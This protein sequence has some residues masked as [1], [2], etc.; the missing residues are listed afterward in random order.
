MKRSMSYFFSASVITFLF[1]A[2]SFA[3]TLNPLFIKKL[4]NP[5]TYSAANEILNQVHAKTICGSSDDLQ[6]VNNYKGN[7]GQ[8]KS[9]VN[10][11]K[12]RV[13][14]M[15]N[16][17]KQSSFGKY[18]SGTL[19]GPNTFI[20]AAHCVGVDTTKHYV[21]FNYEVKAGSSSKLLTQDFYKITKVLESSKNGLDYAILELSGQ[22]GIK[23]GFATVRKSFLENNHLLTIIQHPSGEPKQV[24]VGR[25]I[26]RGGN[27]FY[28]NDLDTEPGSSGSGILD[29]YGSIAGIHTLGGCTSSSNS[30][31][32]SGV[33]MSVI[34]KASSVIK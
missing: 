32:N 22:P 2:T 23:Y 4:Q 11:Y 17:N 12:A 30:R 8:S 16:S 27:Y 29:A 14:A 15:S 10:Q 25:S 34:L 7:L 21:S 20:T 24:E 31:G 1:S 5:D 26:E 19:I 18:C 13:G 28:Y 6:H 3:E 33:K 9:F